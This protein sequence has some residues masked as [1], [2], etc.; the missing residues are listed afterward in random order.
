MVNKDN[1]EKED[2]EV[3]E[4]MLQD[5]KELLS[6]V[7]NNKLNNL[8]DKVEEEEEVNRRNKVR[9]RRSVYDIHSS[10]PRQICAHPP[11]ACTGFAP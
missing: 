10:A 3:K 9:K 11:P 2:K 5:N 8:K 1:P 6:K 4:R 7:P